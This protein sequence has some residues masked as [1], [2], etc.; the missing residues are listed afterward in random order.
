[1]R[2][3]SYN[4]GMAQRMLQGKPW[5]KHG[6]KLDKLLKEFTHVSKAEIV[7]LSELGG[8]RGGLSYAK[9]RMDSM[10]RQASGQGNSIVRG[11]FATC[12]NLRNSD[13]L[14]VGQGCVASS[15][16]NRRSDMHWQAFW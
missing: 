10:L 6:T 5:E 12:F 7:C 15:V 4:L 3:I 1:M 8:F 16:H 2:I 9:I 13:A 14:L 11:N